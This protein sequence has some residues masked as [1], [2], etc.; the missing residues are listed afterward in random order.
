MLGRFI[1]K[2]SFCA[3]KLS[4]P[5]ANENLLKK[6]GITNP[7]IYR[8]LTYFFYLFFRVSEYYEF[9]LNSS[10]HDPDAKSSVKPDSIAD[11]GAFVAYSGKCTGYF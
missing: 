4:N 5:K 8:N 2:Y 3:R 6:F 7:D 1:S 9:G 11:S 10:N